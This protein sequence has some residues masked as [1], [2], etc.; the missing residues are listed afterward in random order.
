MDLGR[1]SAII[2]L[3]ANKSIPEAPPRDSVVDET[4][5]LAT[6]GFN[7]DDTKRHIASPLSKREKQRLF[8]DEA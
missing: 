8:E 4:E 7:C 5:S 2:A 3:A 1:Q 6:T